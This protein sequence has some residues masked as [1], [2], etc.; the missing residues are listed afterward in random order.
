MLDKPSVIISMDIW[1]P[2]SEKTSQH[3]SDKESKGNSHK[4]GQPHRIC[5]SHHLYFTISK[6]GNNNSFGVLILLC[7]Q[8][9]SNAGHHGG[10]SEMKGVLIAMCKQLGIT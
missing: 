7:A 9:T 3:A 4:F 8:W 2:G 5:E 1:Y 10:G 6:F